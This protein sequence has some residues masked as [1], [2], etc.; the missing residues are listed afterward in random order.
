MPED[1]YVIA[2]AGAA[3][4]YNMTMLTLIITIQNTVRVAEILLEEPYAEATLSSPYLKKNTPVTIEIIMNAS[5]WNYETRGN[6]DFVI[7]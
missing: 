1:G 5:A 4:N 7:I 2:R 3:N 6:L